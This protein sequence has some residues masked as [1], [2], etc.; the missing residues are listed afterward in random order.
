MQDEKY[1]FFVKKNVRNWS[2]TLCMRVFE[3]VKAWCG[4]KFKWNEIESG[5][6]EMFLI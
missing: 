5:A 6:V 2:W 4:Q 1:S 3:E